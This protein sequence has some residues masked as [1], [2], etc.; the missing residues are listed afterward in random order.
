VTSKS[1]RLPSEKKI[2][3][4]LKSGLSQIEMFLLTFFLD[5]DVKMMLY[6]RKGFNPISSIKVSNI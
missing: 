4:N 3:K 1:W 5:W 6:G 2:P